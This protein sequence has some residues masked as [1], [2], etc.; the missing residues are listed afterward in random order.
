[1]EQVE[2]PSFGGTHPG[3]GSPNQRLLR[4][5]RNGELP[6]AQDKVEQDSMEPSLVQ[7]VTCG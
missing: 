5:G 7:R 3:V 1:V 2:L 6:K 4:C